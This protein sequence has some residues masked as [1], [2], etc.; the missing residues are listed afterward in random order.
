MASRGR[1]DKDGESIAHQGDTVDRMPVGQEAEVEAVARQLFEQ[2]RLGTVSWSGLPDSDKAPWLAQ[3]GLSLRALA[4]LG[5]RV[6]QPADPLVARA[7]AERTAAQAQSAVREAEKLLRMGEPLLAYNVVQQALAERPGECRLRQLKGL[8]LARSGALRRAN[9]ELAA[10]RD[11]G[12]IDGETMGLLARTHKDLGLA[13]TDGEVREHHLAAAFEIYASGYRESDRCGAVAEAYYTGINA[14]TMAFLRGHILHAREIAAEVEKLCRQALQES[15]ADAYWPQAT[16]AEAA[17]II[18]DQELARKRY[19]AAALLAGTRYGDLSSTRHQARLLLEHQGQSTDWLDSAMRIPPVLVYTGHMIDLPGR[20]QPRFPPEMESK[21]RAEIRR[22]LER[23]EPVAAYG[24]A[25][26]GADILCLECVQ[27]LGGELH[28]VL[29]FP[30]EQF[31]TESVDIRHDRHWRDRFEQLLESANEVLVISEQPPPSGTSTFEY[32]NLTMTGLARLRAQMLDTRLQGLAVWD[33]TGAGDEGGTGSMVS[34]WRRCG[35]P[36]EH[37][38]LSDAAA[39]ASSMQTHKPGHVA[40]QPASGAGQGAFEYKIK[41]MLF[42]DAV[43]YSRLSEEQIP[44]F[45]KHYVGTVAEFN[46]QTSHKAVHVETAGDGMYMVF[47]DTGTAAH[48]ALGLS[49]LINNQDWQSL[50]LP[51]DMGMRI[52]LHCGPVFIGR[53]PITGAPLFTGIHTSR[54]A[55]IQPITPPGQVYASSAFAAVAAVRGIAGLRFSYIGRTEL[56]KHYGALPLYHV[57]PLEFPVARREQEIRKPAAT[58]RKQSKRAA[59]SPTAR[60]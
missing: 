30:A 52:G 12:S 15:S 21:V 19:A 43:G 54:T 27:E 24:S 37:V 38:A 2:Q 51:E 31:L 23:L 18:G 22:R 14:A 55:R 1:T 5:Y 29:P 50:G 36:L 6:E 28:I 4:D 48:Y 20:S 26:C 58:V 25:A 16:L 47:D 17:L 46:E 40:E 8:A 11:E 32:A 39:P 9:E 49:E 10:L 41:A 57:K 35:V 7:A 34:M 42:A 60:S 45:F 53:D 59:S 56:A 3:A 33:G 13:A 44:H